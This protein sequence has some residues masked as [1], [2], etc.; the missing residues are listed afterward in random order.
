MTDDED[1]WR[2]PPP[3][4]HRIV[5]HQGTERAFTGSYR[6]EK[7]QGFD[8]RIDCGTP[9][10]R[11]ETKDAPDSG[12]QSVYAPVDEGTV[13]AHRDASRGMARTEIGC[14]A[15]DGPLGLLFPDGPRPTGL[16]YCVNGNSPIL[17]RHGRSHV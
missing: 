13:V 3:E 10:L 6:N 2:R 4:R 14:A 5:R 16:R 15:Y 9:L 11:S 7:M 1:L 17:L 8:N 12:R